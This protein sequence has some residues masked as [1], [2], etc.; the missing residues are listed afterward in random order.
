VLTI[1]LHV[2]DALYRFVVSGSFENCSP[3]D[4][5]AK[6]FDVSNFEMIAESDTDVYMNGSVKFMRDVGSNT[7]VHIFYEKL[8]RGQWNIEVFNA[9]RSSFC[10]SL[11]NPMEGWY[12]KTK[13]LKGCPLKAGV[14]SAL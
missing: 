8:I 6:A 5:D 2:S 14:R 13:K 4:Q 3:Q 1:Y 11:Q 9:N 7:G 10:A 12:I